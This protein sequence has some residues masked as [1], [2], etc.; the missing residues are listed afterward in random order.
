MRPAET[1]SE[2][3]FTMG[4]D[5]QGVLNSFQGYMPT[6]ILAGCIEVL[7]FVLTLYKSVQ[8]IKKENSIV[9]RILLRD[10][11]LSLPQLSL[12]TV[13]ISAQ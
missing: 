1:G 7:V 6:I 5:Y 10:G 8:V 9:L 11:E 2:V 12:A 13:L 4:F 3:R